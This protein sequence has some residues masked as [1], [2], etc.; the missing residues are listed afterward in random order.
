VAAASLDF[1]VEGPAPLPPPEEPAP[2]PPPPPPDQPDLLISGLQNSTSIIVKNVGKAGAGPFDVTIHDAAGR[3]QT[4][5][6]D[7][8]LAAGDQAAVPGQ[9]CTSGRVFTA[10]SANEVAESNEGNNTHSCA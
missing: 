10:D 2:P 1:T 8:G 3:T 5:R 7:N 9:T 6:F 4:A